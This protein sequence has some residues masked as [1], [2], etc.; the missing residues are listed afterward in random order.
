MT[1][2]QQS[3]RAYFAEALAEQCNGDPI[4]DFF[5]GPP[6]PAAL[7]PRAFPMVQREDSASD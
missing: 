6:A 2:P 7:A 5:F 4:P 3:A 1:G